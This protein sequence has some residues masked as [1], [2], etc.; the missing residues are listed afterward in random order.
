MI[1]ANVDMIR[2][3]IREILRVV[4]SL[5]RSGGKPMEIKALREEAWRLE[6]VAHYLEKN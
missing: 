5:E 4:R 1:N 3:A 2:T 6:R